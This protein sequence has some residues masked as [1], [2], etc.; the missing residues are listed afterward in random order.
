[1]TDM[2]IKC[3]VTSRLIKCVYTLKCVDTVVVGS[4]G[5]V[6]MLLVSYVIHSLKA[7]SSMKSMR[8][9]DN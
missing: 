4:I 3:I 8:E 5:E 7:M 9:W 6:S 2:L 1:M